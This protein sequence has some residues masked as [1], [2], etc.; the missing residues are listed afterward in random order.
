MR[1]SHSQ[2]SIH[3]GQLDSGRGAAA[4]RLLPSAAFGARAAVLAGVVATA[5][6]T[7]APAASAAASP[8]AATHVLATVTL[9]GPAGG[10]IT[11]ADSTC[12]M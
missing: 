8:T 3:D 9:H 6:A 7:A 2:A 1:N 11:P 5:C 4:A 10:F 12:C